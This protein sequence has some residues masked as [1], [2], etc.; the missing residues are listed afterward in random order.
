MAQAQAKPTA[1]Q[2]GSTPSQQQQQ[3]GSAPTQQQGQ[4]FR[5]WA[6]I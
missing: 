3:G 4:I 6:S 1:Q 2:G 5:D